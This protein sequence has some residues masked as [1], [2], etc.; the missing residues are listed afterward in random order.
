MFDEVEEL[1]SEAVT[2]G[3][4]VRVSSDYVD[5]ESRPD[6][7]HYFWIY[8]VRIDNDSDQTVTLKRRTWHIA[9]ALGHSFVVEGEGVIGEQ[10]VLS[11]GDAYEY[12]SGTPL[13][14]P[15]GMMFGAYHMDR[16]NGST[17]QAMIPPFSLDSP[18]DH[19][20]MS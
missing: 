19:R 3:I 17:F 13:S 2:D 20:R 14:A 9:D 15:S 7:G 16:E 5:D 11:P 8:T 12:T 4:R 10:P 6:E 1:V 18:Y